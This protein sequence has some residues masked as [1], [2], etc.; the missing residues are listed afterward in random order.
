MSL[1]GRRVAYKT[2]PR[3][4]FRFIDPPLYLLTAF[5]MI[6]TGI[7]TLAVTLLTAARSTLALPSAE[8][9]SALEASANS[10][11]CHT[12][13]KGYLVGFD[14][15]GFLLGISSSTCL[16]DSFLSGKSLSSSGLRRTLPKKYLTFPTGRRRRNRSMLTSRSVYQSSISRVQAS[17]CH[18]F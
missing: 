8:G 17:S 3:L 9:S 4:R 15:S 12:I 5:T 10:T 2:S 14:S 1:L 13:L 6:L 16:Y 18:T 7:S 11:N